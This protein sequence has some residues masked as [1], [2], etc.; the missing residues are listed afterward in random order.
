[1]AAISNQH[2]RDRAIQGSETI[3]D[4]WLVINAYAGR[5]SEIVLFGCMLCNILEMLPGVS[6]SST[7]TST[8]LGVQIVSLDIGG[9]SLSSMAHHARD[10]GAEKAADVATLT[11]RFLIG[12]MVVTLLTVS[13][14]VLYPHLKD[15]TKPVENAMVLIRV[16]MTVLYSSVIHSLRSSVLEVSPAHQP[17]IQIEDKPE[18]PEET[19]PETTVEELPVQLNEIEAQKESVRVSPKRETKPKQTAKQKALQIIAKQ[20]D[21]DP[22][23]LSKKLSVSEQYARKLLAEQK[24]N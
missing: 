7:F 18:T 20:P 6:L 3:T 17:T 13:V 12:L 4:I 8:V 19:T 2:W 15:Y 14:G 23:T 5:L 16:V 10:N 1:M 22:V 11:S 9:L 24:G 21:I